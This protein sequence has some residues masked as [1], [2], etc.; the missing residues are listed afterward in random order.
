MVLSCDSTRGGQIQVA[1]SR[2]Y[3][4]LPLL[5]NPQ[6]VLLRKVHEFRPLLLRSLFLTV[7]KKTL[8]SPPHESRQ[9]QRLS[10]H[11]VPCGNGRRDEV[12]WMKLGKTKIKSTPG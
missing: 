8:W 10:Y 11:L 5:Q 12:G 2:L 6:N 3:A 9:Y 4:K 1:I 7:F